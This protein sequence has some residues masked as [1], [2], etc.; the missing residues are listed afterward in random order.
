MFGTVPKPVESIIFIISL[1]VWLLC[2][3]IHHSPLTTDL[4]EKQCDGEPW[5]AQAGPTLGKLRRAIRWIWK[6]H[7][8]D[9]VQ[10][11]PKVCFGDLAEYEDAVGK[12]KESPSIGWA[13]ETPVPGVRWLC[14]L[15]SIGTGITRAG[16]PKGQ[17]NGYTFDRWSDRRKGHS[18]NHKR[19]EV[20]SLWFVWI[21][22]PSEVH[23]LWHVQPCGL[24]AII[25]TSVVELVNPVS[26]PDQHHSAR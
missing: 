18:C 8:A 6:V 1:I 10:P 20:P 4:L 9:E 13:N 14:T 15:R 23:P 25:S 7:E 19:N 3:T 11:L 24:A 17:S 12:L 21:R 2:I 26:Y 16:E 5:R 22:C